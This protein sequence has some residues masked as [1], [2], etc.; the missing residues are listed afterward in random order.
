MRETAE[1]KKPKVPAKKFPPRPKK[2]PPRPG[3]E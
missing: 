2:L 3:D 1:V